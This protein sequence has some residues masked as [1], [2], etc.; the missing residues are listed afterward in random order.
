MINIGLGALMYLYSEGGCATGLMEIEGKLYDFD[1]VNGSAVSGL[2][3]VGIDTY[4]FSPD[5]FTAQTGFITLEGQTMY[6]GSDYKMVTGL[7]N[8]DGKL[9]YFS[10]KG[11]LYTGALK[12]TDATYYF[13]D[14]TGAAV[15]GWYTT[16]SNYRFILILKLSRR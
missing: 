6:F 3:V 9:Y 13:D 1:A 10:E 15:S 16:I 12:G 7:Q 8:I 2:Q 5:S 14:N 11:Y 4:Y